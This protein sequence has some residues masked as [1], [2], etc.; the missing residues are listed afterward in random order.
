MRAPEP[1]AL[2]WGDPAWQY[3]C[4]ARQH[5]EADDSP[6]SAKL[7][8]PLQQVVHITFVMV[9]RET[10]PQPIAAVVGR[11]PCRR[12]ASMQLGRALGPE[13]QEVAAL[14]DVSPR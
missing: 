4:S 11:D 10:E 2:R 1:S 3:S 8:D 14:H 7:R 5:S 13:C 9:D 12:Q 6:S